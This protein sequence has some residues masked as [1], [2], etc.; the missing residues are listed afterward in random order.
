LFNQLYIDLKRE[1]ASTPWTDSDRER[2]PRTDAPHRDP[3]ASLA[4]VLPR[5]APDTCASRCVGRYLLGEA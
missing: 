1:M 4:D 2:H 3:L 5:E